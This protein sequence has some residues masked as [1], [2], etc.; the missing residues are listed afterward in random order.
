MKKLFIAFVAMSLFGAVQVSIA[1]EAFVVDATAE[2]VLI[3]SQR[4]GGCMLR[5]D[6]TLA[7]YGLN[8][9]SRWVA[10]SCDGTFASRDIAFRQLDQAQ[11]ALTLGK[12]INLVVDDSKKH[13]GYCFASR[14]NL[15]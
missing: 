12:K 13:N 6:K 15:K 9:P 8:C 2:R 5:T 4:Y 1:Q 3:D 11:I 7:D 10:F 14:T